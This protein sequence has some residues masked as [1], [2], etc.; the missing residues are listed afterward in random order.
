MVLCPELEVLHVPVARNLLPA[1][2]EFEQDLVLV[3]APDAVVPV[4]ECQV[5]HA[6]PVFR[7]S[8][9]SVLPFVR[10]STML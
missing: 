4:Q 5:F 3:P 1:Q 7:R 10:E 8:I 9:R 2:K 6:V